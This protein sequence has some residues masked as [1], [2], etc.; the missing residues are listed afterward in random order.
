MAALL[1][2]MQGNTM[3]LW[4]LK[5]EQLAVLG[6]TRDELRSQVL[7]GH[8]TGEAGMQQLRALVAAKQVAAMESGAGRQAAPQT[9]AAQQPVQVQQSQQEYVPQWRAQQQAQQTAANQQYQV[10]PPTP[11][12]D[13]QPEMSPAERRELW[14][15]QR[16]GQGQ[17]QQQQQQQQQ[18]QPGGGQK[19]QQS[20]APAPVRASVRDLLNERRIRLPQYA[21]GTYNQMMCPECQGGD[22]S[23]QG[24]AAA[25]LAC[26]L[27]DQLQLAATIAVCAAV[28]RLLM[29]VCLLALC[30]HLR[31]P[32]SLR[33]PVCV[34]VRRA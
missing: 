31:L 16:Q 27:G 13:Q 22:K 19:Q 28:M 4:R 8:G 3:Q 17:Q 7:T 21:P 6:V 20:G 23:E 1:A 2:D 9:T 11:L 32:A 29:L 15:Q 33:L 34:Q 14:R 25:R 30:A 12:A 24:A 18:G 26:R 5:P 10:P